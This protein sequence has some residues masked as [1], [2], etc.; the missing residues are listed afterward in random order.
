MDLYRAVKAPVAPFLR[1]HWRHPVARGLAQGARR[2]LRLYENG[3]HDLFT[4]GEASYLRRLP[5]GTVRTAIDVG[6]YR[7][8]WTGLLLDAQAQAHVHAVEATPATA[9]ALRASLDGED[10]VTVHPVALGAS[11]GQLPLFVSPRGPNEN[12]L[13]DAGDGRPTLSVPVRAGDDLVAEV[14]IDHI[15]I[16]KIDS[17]G[18]DLDVLRGFARTIAAGA[19]D[20]VQFEYTPWNIRSR[21]LLIDFYELLE[22]HGYRIGKIHPAD[23][24]FKGY[25]EADENFVG[26][27]CV[28]VRGERR[29]LLEAIAG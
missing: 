13:V 22:P 19:I 29:D 18:H 15:D 11:A 8:E 10:R 17:E 27:A 5:P 14:G 25:E 23:V 12:S 16:L 20:V 2:Y 24:A 1:T 21:A 4:N 9:T 7:G 6:A 26:P 28:A 3:S